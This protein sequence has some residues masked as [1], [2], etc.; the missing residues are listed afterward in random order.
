MWRRLGREWRLH[1]SS[2]ELTRANYPRSDFAAVWPA[3]QSGRD[4]LKRGRW[5]IFD[6]ADLKNELRSPNRERVQGRRGTMANWL[7]SRIAFS[8]AACVL[9][10]ATMAVAQTAPP[11]SAPGT[12]RSGVAPR[13]AARASP[14][15]PRAAEL[16]AREKLNAWT[17]G[18]AAGLLEG[19][20]IRFA[21]E[22]ARVVDDGDNLHV[23]PI[24]TRG[25][26]E[27]LESLLYLR[28]VDVGIINSDSLEEIRNVVPDIQ[29]RIVSIL[30]LFPS[31]LH[32][33]VRPEIN[34][35][36]DLAGKKVNF[37]TPGTAAAYTGP[38]VFKALNLE[39]DSTFIPHQV[40][41]EQLKSGS[42][43]A[44]VFVTSKP[45]EPFNRAWE[46][47]FKFLSVDYDDRFLQY[48]LPATLTSKDYPRLIKEGEEV[49]T[50]SVPAVLAAFNWPK[51]SQRYQRVA[52][53]TTR[54]FDRIDELRKPGFH[55]KWAEVNLAA[56][57]PGLK[58]FAAAQEW[59][60]Q[61]AAP[62]AGSP[63]TRGPE[64]PADTAAVRAQVRRAAP[65]D[66]AEQERLFQE[67]LK[68][69]GRQ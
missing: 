61:R 19:A 48:Y 30:N 54:L 6:R 13:L 12:S 20:P 4:R 25:P 17:V 52:R 31:E 1:V 33:F 67:F 22:I 64:N 53:L 69:R 10:L 3:R 41:L 44:V 21:A 62:P 57:V 39:V 7:A 45:V 42:V 38:L 5:R 18:L 49:P 23:L 59:L 8:G 43:A 47:G 27:N 2:R 65:G 56:G 50:I 29:Q 35:L 9:L 28:G 51:A 55:P 26:F 46:P 63:E 32:V 11:Q 14:R 66:P 16:P 40:A 68:W 15:A 58:R 60:N 34:S 36:Q 37:N 24:V